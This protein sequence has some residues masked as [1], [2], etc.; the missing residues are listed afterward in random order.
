MK[1]DNFTK[2]D[3]DTRGIKMIAMHFFMSTQAPGFHLLRTWLML[4]CLLASPWVNAQDQSLKLTNVPSHNLGSH[5]QFLRDSSG[6]LTVQD[7]AKL[8]AN[9]WRPLNQDMSLGFTSDVIWVRVILTRTHP[10]NPTRWN[11]VLGQSILKDARLYK[12]LQ[13]GT[14]EEIYGTQVDSTIQRELINRYPA[15]DISDY[16]LSEKNYY[17]RIESDTAL[18]MSIKA[19]QTDVFFEQTGNENF[20]WG[21]LFGG[22]ILTIIF[23]IIFWSQ[24][25]EKTHKIYVLYISINF[26]SALSSGGWPTLLSNSLTSSIQIILLGTWI[27]LSI[28][29]GTKFS[30]TFIDLPKKWPIFSNFIVK[31]SLMVTTI[32]LIMIFN[33]YYNLIMPVLQGYSIFII[34]NFMLIGVYFSI[35]GDNKAKFFV[36][37]FSFFYIGVVWRYMRNTGI[38]EPNFLNENI[39]QIAAFF[40]MIVMSVGIFASYSKLKKEKEN[41]EYR[42]VTESTLRIQ[43]REFLSLVSHEFRTPLTIAGASA[44]NLLKDNTLGSNAKT[45]VEKII[46]ALERMSSLMETYLSKERLLMDAQTIKQEKIDLR[47]LCRQAIKDASEGVKTEIKLQAHGEYI[48]TGDAN[49]L[50]I[51]LNNLLQ[52]AQKYSPEPDSIV[53]RLTKSKDFNELLVSDQGPGI[54]EEELSK[55]FTRYFRGKNAMN[56]PGAGLGLHLI[57]TIALRHGGQVS[58]RNLPDKGCEFC[59]SLPR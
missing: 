50:S 13:N 26:L 28:F 53:V 41:A 45:R 21:L 38:I 5:A 3:N 35:K 31:L 40:H 7:V 55:I 19:V 17:I 43:Q 12:P 52:N 34:F 9:Q 37:A 22:Y 20:I 14:F 24:T 57:Q 4:C 36:F 58:V 48:T 39:Y 56:L 32:G 42:A 16:T 44:D 1:Y 15:F 46:R 30:A 23:Y 18:N 49:L 29:I 54:P 11:L 27:S 6:Q 33:G 10:E 25:K 51:A 47:E 2:N 8:S 59:L